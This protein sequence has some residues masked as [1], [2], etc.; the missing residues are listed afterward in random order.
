MFSL[1]SCASASAAFL[2]FF[3]F[4]CLII[5]WI[6]IVVRDPV[7]RAGTT[8]EMTSVLFETS[9]VESRTPRNI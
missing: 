7:A 1:V 5:R 3:I 4:S 9:I 6:R 8:R 2:S